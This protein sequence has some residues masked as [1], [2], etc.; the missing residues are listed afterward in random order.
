[1]ADLGSLAQRCSS[2]VYARVANSRTLVQAQ[3]GSQIKAAFARADGAWNQ[4]A[5]RSRTRRA[6]TPTYKPFGS[7]SAATNAPAAMT[8][9][10]AIVT[11]G[12]TMLDAPSQHPS[13]M[14]IGAFWCGP[15][16]LEAGPISCVL[17]MSCTPGARVTPRPIVTQS[18]PSIKQLRLMKDWSPIKHLFDPKKDE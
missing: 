12:S 5:T 2:K 15:A 14:A 3:V 9:P 18:D 7:V 8:Q 16:R 13:P 4:G 1:M 10:G 6:G 11:P 17:V